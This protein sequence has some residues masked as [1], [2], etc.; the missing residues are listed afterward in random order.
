MY[1]GDDKYLSKEINTQTSVLKYNSTTYLDIGVV[2]VGEDVILTITTLS[3]ATGNVTLKIND[4][5]ETLTLNNSKATYTIKNIK[6]GDYFISAVY[7]GDD[8]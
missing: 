3:D 6:R 8:K 7:N 4:K 2:N 5:I 1:F